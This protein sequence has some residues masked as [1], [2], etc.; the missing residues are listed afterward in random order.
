M[1]EKLEAVEKRYDELTKMI[2]D[3]EIISNQSEWQ[4][5]M[6]EH[7]S[8]EDIVLKFREYKKIKQEMEEAEELMQ[9]PDMKEL[10]EEEYYNLD[11]YF[12][13][14][15]NN[16]LTEFIKLALHDDN[17][18]GK[19]DTQTFR[20]LNFFKLSLLIIL[21]FRLLDLFICS[22]LSSYILIFLILIS[23]FI[24]KSNCFALIFFSNDI[25]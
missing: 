12:R 20:K 4:K 7:A 24:F 21:F 13:L 16:N 1:F 5:L 15:M 22:C 3:P 25:K 8:M 6:K 2:A 11:D 10:A 14:M 18:L 9:D 23:T 19:A 17:F